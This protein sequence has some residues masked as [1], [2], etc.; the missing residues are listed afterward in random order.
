[1]PRDYANGGTIGIDMGQSKRERHSPCCKRPIQGSYDVAKCGNGRD[2]LRQVIRVQDNKK[3]YELMQQFS[4]HNQA[5]IA[6]RQMAA[7]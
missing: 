2:P 4:I 5:D 7:A 6:R 1:M 3:L